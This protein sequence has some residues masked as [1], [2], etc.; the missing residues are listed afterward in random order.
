MKQNINKDN[1]QIENKKIDDDKTTDNSKL[2]K[3][4]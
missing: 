1:N 2:N 3:R 4:R